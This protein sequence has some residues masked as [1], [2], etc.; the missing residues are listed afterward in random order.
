VVCNG[1]HQPREVLTSAGAVEVVP[2]RVDDRRTDPN[3]GER[4]RSASGILPPWRRKIPK[5]NEVLPLLYLHGLSSGDLWTRAEA[6]PRLFGWAVGVGDHE[7]DRD[8]PRGTVE[9]DSDRRR[10]RRGGA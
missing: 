9:G 2:P 10:Q 5:I 6:V 1:S 7:A 4:A 8:R 3:T